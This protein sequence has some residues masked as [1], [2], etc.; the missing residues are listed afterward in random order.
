MTSLYD[1][2]SPAI[3]H[4]QIRNGQGLSMHIL[5]AGDSSPDRPLMLL[6]HGFPELAF[7]WR[8]VMVPLAAAGYYVVAPDHRGYGLT[9]GW[10]GTYD[11][12]V[13]SFGIAN[14]TCDTLG[15]VAALGRSHVD[16][17]VG[18]D[19]GSFL[20]HSCS[21]IRP[22]VFRSLV[23]MSAPGTTPPPLPCGEPAETP[24]ASVPDIHAELAALSRPRK[25][26]QWYY[27]ERRAA[28]DMLEAPEGFHAFLRA[29][30]HMK[31]A[32]WPDNRP[33]KLA[34]WTA[35]ELAKLPTYYIM[36]L[37]H[38][39]PDAVRASMPDEDAIANCAWLTDDE[40]SV[41]TASFQRT[42]LQGAL[43][44]YRC[45]TEGR[46]ANVMALYSG[47]KITVP[48]TFISGA[49]DWGIHQSPGALERLCT[50]DTTDFR[51]CHLIDGAGHW[52]Q[53]EQP[54]AVVDHVL[55]FAEGVG[56]RP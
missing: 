15:L 38:T 34:A 47:A 50:V 29:Y 42:G 35:P 11:G 43:N 54:S 33:F 9:T 7:S 25:H 31:S 26:Y 28:Q 32:D 13:D 39:M 19:F 1:L 52:V 18:H 16:V 37:A 46:N 56:Q 27:S 24:L 51:G 53:Q 49:Q 22:D 30:Y 12:P 40:L 41:Y 48:S 23:M 10:D 8:K 55:A 45:R 14:L 2:I 4:R 21:M 20:A 36:D 17:L 44:W 3:R 5:E 6:L